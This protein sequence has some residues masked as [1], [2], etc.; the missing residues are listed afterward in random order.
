MKK[1]LMKNLLSVLMTL[2]ALGLL[3]SCG[4]SDGDSG[5][6][7]GTTGTLSM[8]LTDAATDGYKAVYVTIDR[9]DVHSGEEGSDSG[10]WTTVAQPGETYNLLTLVNGV[11]AELGQELLETGTYGQLRLIIGATA[12]DEVNILGNQHPHA[13]YVINM[14]DEAH[15]L[16]VPSGPQTGIKLTHG[17][18]IFPG[19]MTELILDFDASRSVVKRGQN[20]NNKEYK[21]LLKPTIK[22]LDFVN[23]ADISGTVTKDNTDLNNRAYVTAQT[24]DSAADQIEDEVTIEAGTVTTNAGEYALA[25]DPGTYNVIVTAS[26]YEAACKAVS[27]V[28]AETVTTVDFSLTPLTTTTGTI[29]GTISIPAVEEGEED[30]YAVLSVRQD[31]ACGETTETVIVKTDQIAAGGTYE[32]TLPTG[33]YTIVATSDGYETNSE[34]VT[35]DSEGNIPEDPLNFDFTTP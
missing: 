3:V 9:I 1:I 35:V 19:Q 29:T 14:E 13:N 6:S 22:V 17:F 30:P 27:I 10:N 11:F 21:Y 23:T 32:F 33:N 2:M 34:A 24:T 25:L 5:S 4:S 26:R 15:Q 28:E 7:G 12:E 16:K 31:L 8:S 18:E 20:K